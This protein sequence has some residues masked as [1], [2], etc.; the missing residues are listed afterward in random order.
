M[1]RRCKCRFVRLNT[2]DL[3]Y[4]LQ[5]NLVA[6]L[7]TPGGKQS[8]PQF[9]AKPIPL[10]IDLVVPASSGH[11]KVTSPAAYA[12]VALLSSRTNCCHRVFAKT[13][14]NSANT[15]LSLR[16]L[17]RSV[18]RSAA[19]FSTKAVRPQTALRQTAAFQPAWTVA[20]PRLTVS[21]SMSAARREDSGSMY[22]AN[23]K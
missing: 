13:T 18:P 19:R 12:F 3:E 14:I 11:R 9:G 5:S 23:S 1:Q 21:F 20:V 17:A 16:N 4:V 8:A 15:M 22:C 6:L 2:R 7:S 10:H